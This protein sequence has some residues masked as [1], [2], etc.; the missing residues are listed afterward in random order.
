MPILTV[1][2]YIHSKYYKLFSNEYTS[3]ADT[4]SQGSEFLNINA[5]NSL[6]SHSYTEVWLPQLSRVLIA[7]SGDHGNLTGLTSDMELMTIDT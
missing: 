7:G 2:C 3:V 5:Y 1:S 4:T 6:P